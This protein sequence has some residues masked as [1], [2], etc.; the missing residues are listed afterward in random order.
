MIYAYFDEHGRVT[1]AFN[2]ATVAE[3][4]DGAVELTAEQ[5]ADRFDLRLVDG[6]LAADPL[7]QDIDSLKAAKSREINRARLAANRAA[8]PFAGKEI[9]CDALS[10]SDIDGVAAFVALHDTLPPGFPGVW[11]AVDNSFVTVAD[12]ATFRAL[13]GAMVSQGAENFQHSEDLK[14]ALARASTPDEVKA[15]VW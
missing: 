11:K 4:P 2:D 7:S 12:V 8:F 5:F 14:A 3:L 6:A 9:A 13:V 15:I 1:E 10:R